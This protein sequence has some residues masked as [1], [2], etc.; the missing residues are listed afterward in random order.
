MTTI[1]A[2]DGSNRVRSRALTLLKRLR[3]RTL[4]SARLRTL[5][6]FLHHSKQRVATL[7]FVLRA[8]V[9]RLWVSRVVSLPTWMPQ[10]M[11]LG[12][13]NSNSY[14]YDDG[15]GKTVTNTSVNYS[16]ADREPLGGTQNED[17]HSIRS[18]IIEVI[19]NSENLND[20]DLTPC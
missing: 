20:V 15:S 5:K 12:Y 11:L 3:M 6:V 14:S 13:A 9:M 8:L 1:F 16:S 19:D 4:V 17:A 2:A 10:V 7:M 18:S